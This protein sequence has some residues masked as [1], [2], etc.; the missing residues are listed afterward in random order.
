M[1]ALA[2]HDELTVTR[3]LSSSSCLSLRCSSISSLSSFSFLRQKK[4]D[5]QVPIVCWLLG[6]FSWKTIII[7]KR[8][9]LSPDQAEK[10]LKKHQDHIQKVEKTKL[11]APVNSSKFDDWHE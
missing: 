9:D 10:K 2:V 7:G 1:F 11:Q 8:F 3:D 4:K 5:N 6:V